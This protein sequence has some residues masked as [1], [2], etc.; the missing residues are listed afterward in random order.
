MPTISSK[1]NTDIAVDSIDTL[2][3]GASKTLKDSRVEKPL[4][5]AELLLADLLGWNRIK[6]YT[7]GSFQPDKTVIQK[8]NERIIRRSNGEPVAY[9]VG[10]KDFHNYRFMVSNW[11]L[12]P[13]P[14]TEYL[15]DVVL[16]EKFTDGFSKMI[17][18]SSNL[19]EKVFFFSPSRSIRQ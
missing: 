15:V 1:Q 11:V 17:S 13:R 6:L 12:I 10:Y 18:S 7:N 19:S 4:L 8:Y 5:E 14:E 2:L 3:S 9:I 16:N